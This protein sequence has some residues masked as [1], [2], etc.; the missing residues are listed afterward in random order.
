MASS[1][2]TYVNVPV[3]LYVDVDVGFEPTLWD[4]N[5]SYNDVV[6]ETYKGGSLYSRRYYSL[7]LELGRRYYT[8]VFD[9]SVPDPDTYSVRAGWR[10]VYVALPYGYPEAE[11]VWSK[12]ITITVETAPPTTPPTAPPTA[13]AVPEWVKYL[14]LGAAGA[15][16]VAVVVSAVRKRRR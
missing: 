11:Y 9:W 1:N 3:K 7:S 16:G 14:A 5:Y 8:W 13:P 10:L 4:V 15:L 6:I 2:V 12:P